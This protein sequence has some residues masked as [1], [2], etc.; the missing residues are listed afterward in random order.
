MCPEETEGWEGNGIRE[1]EGEGHELN[2]HG[3]RRALPRATCLAQP[4]LSLYVQP[5]TSLLKTPTTTVSPWLLLGKA[6]GLGHVLLPV[7]E[8]S[9]WRPEGWGRPQV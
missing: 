2:A 3:G 6:Q 4:P 1:Q 9:P 5:A 7:L 8:L